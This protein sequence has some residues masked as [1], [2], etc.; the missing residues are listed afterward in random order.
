MFLLHVV[1]SCPKPYVLFAINYLY[2]LEPGGKVRTEFFNEDGNPSYKYFYS[3]AD[4]VAA[5]MRRVKNSIKSE[6]RMVKE[7]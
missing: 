4:S 1:C 7:L 2:S 6:S 3:N 5:T